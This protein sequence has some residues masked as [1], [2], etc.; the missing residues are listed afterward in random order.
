MIVNVPGYLTF[1]FGMQDVLQQS[2]MHMPTGMTLAWH[3]RIKAQFP[4]CS[5]R[6]P[7]NSYIRPK[8]KAEKEVVDPTGPEGEEASA[9]LASPA[10]TTKKAGSKM[11]PSA[12]SAVSGAQARGGGSDR[13]EYKSSMR[14]GPTALPSTCIL[15]F[16]VNGIRAVLN[17]ASRSPLSSRL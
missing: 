6:A 12:A 1:G 7:F 13:P 16:N 2:A 8:R 4:T 9:P 11:K 3:A 17:K 15:S 14:P 10:A 5:K